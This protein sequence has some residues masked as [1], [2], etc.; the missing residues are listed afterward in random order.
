ML[1]SH[2][3]LNLLIGMFSLAGVLIF[4]VVF[5]SGPPFGPV[6]HRAEGV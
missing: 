4:L 3:G 6:A 2:N 1:F 5:F